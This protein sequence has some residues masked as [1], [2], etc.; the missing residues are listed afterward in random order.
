MSIQQTNEERRAQWRAQYQARK[1]REPPTEP[2]SIVPPHVKQEMERATAAPQTITA[3]VLGDPLPGRS[4]WDKKL[5]RG[6]P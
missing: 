1:E 6:R 2:R 3:L 4:A 5:K